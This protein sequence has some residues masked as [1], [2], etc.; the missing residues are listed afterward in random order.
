MTRRLAGALAVLLLLFAA[1]MAR[2]QE[3]DVELVFAVDGSGS[4]D[5]AEFALQRQ[6]YAEAI[7][8]P[9]VIRVIQAGAIGRIA[10]ALME[11]GAAESQHTIVDWMVIHDAAS[12]HAFAERVLRAPRAAWGYNSI[13]GA[14]D[15]SRRLIETNGFEGLRKVIDVSADGGHYGGR[16]VRQARD[17]AV[18][19]GITINGLVI[20][21]PHGGLRYR[22]MPLDEHFEQDVIGGAG[23]FVMT[24][25]SRAKIAT[26]LLAK[27]IREIAATP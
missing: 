13:S 18:A 20:M 14:I 12:A 17:E 24:V 4:I 25:E 15:H 16:P 9:K 23:A 3:V 6:G 26:T 10:V 2:A 5:E 8:D 11:W 19:A 1:G 22:G 7:T 21:T 27:L